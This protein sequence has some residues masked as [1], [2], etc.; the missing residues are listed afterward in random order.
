M[1][2]VKKDVVLAE[3]RTALDSVDA[4]AVDALERQIL[5]SREV[6]CC[7]YGRS[8]LCGRAFAM[9]LMHLGIASGVVGDTLARPIQAGD[10]LVVTSA[11]GSSKALALMAAK[12]R[13]LGAQV[14]LI[15]AD[16]A[17]ELA[18]WADIVVLVQA[19]TKCVAQDRQISV[20]PMGSLFE[21]AVFVLLDLI[22]ADLMET[23]GICNEDMVKRH[24]NLE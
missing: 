19:Q 14:A 2:L 15:T 18:E 12:A 3:L 24:A 20:M 9:R 11:S 8:G 21:E 23:T 13:E 7:G 1:A 4:E 5:Q 22:V 17:S 16:E 10:L 6:F